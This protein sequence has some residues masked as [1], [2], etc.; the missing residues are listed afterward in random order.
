MVKD[1]V[2]GEDGGATAV[3]RRMAIPRGTF[4]VVA[5]DGISVSQGDKDLSAKKGETVEL[6]GGVIQA[7]FNDGAIEP[8]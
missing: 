7:L 5:K 3:V 6:E 1:T 2:K 4:K 8:A